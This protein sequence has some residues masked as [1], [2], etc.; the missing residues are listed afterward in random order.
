MA[1]N[2]K[3]TAHLKT[4]LNKYGENYDRIFKK[5]EIEENLCCTICG[6]LEEDNCGCHEKSADNL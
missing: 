3:E 1:Q 2:F 4:D 5:K 6:E